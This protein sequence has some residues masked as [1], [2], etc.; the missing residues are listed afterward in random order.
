V[1]GGTLQ[2]Q[3]TFQFD[4]RAMRK[5]DKGILFSRIDNT[6]SVGTASTVLVRGRIRVLCL[7]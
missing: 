5:I 2:N 1:A 4:L 3:A 7:T 6:N